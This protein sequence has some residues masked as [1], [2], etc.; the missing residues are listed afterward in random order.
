[1]PDL[2]PALYVL[3]EAAN[4]LE[5]LA[6]PSLP[7]EFRDRVSQIRLDEFEHQSRSGR[8]LDE[9]LCVADIGTAPVWARHRELAVS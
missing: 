7:D 2:H 6:G 5:M 9:T 1:M 4:H 8:S 3:D